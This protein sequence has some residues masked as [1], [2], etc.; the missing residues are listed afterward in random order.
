MTIEQFV[1]SEPTDRNQ[2]R[3]IVL[4]GRN[5]A[6]YKFALAKSLTHF[7]V[8]GRES[9]PLTELAIPFVAEICAHLK[10]SPRQ[11]TSGQSRFLDQCLKFNRGEISL[12]SLHASTVRLGFQNVIDAFHR[13]GTSDVP[14][15]FFIDKRQ[16]SQPSIIIAPS[17]QSIIEAGSTAADEETEARWRLVETAWDIG[18][19]P[20]VIDFDR[21][22]EFLIHPTRRRPITSTRSA[23]NG[24]Q[25]G[26][27]FYC[28]QPISISVSSMDLADVDHLFPHVLQ[29]L[30][31]LPNVDGV[32]NLVLACQACNRG[33]KG[34]FDSTP[35]V[36]Y[37]ER[38]HRRN[39]YLI[40]SHHPLRETLMQQT[41]KTSESRRAFLQAVLDVALSY[42]PTPW[43]ANPSGPA[44]L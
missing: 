26:R 13:V 6:S 19:S 37:L 24:Y 39:E 30:G 18:L 31:L 16:S 36:K 40:L 28:F 42:S 8:S 15:R 21:G 12:E 11:T 44:S 41:G 1:L 4:F 3:S 27:C 43:S 35:A 7:A 32:W 22:S 23:L 9:V 33:A 5:V 17:M 20:H 38:L 2:F 29:R 34:K 25:K 10:E 14:T